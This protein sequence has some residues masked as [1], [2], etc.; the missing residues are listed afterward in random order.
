MHRFHSLSWV[1]GVSIIA[2]GLSTTP[3]QADSSYSDITG[4]NIW[5]NTAPIFDTDERLDPALIERVQQLNAESEQAFQACNAAITQA[6][7]NVPTTRRFARQSK[8][9]RTHS[10]LA[11]TPHTTP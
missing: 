9:R 5:N 3:A 8:E 11:G 10:S 6:E 1:V 4:T 2:M 7:Q